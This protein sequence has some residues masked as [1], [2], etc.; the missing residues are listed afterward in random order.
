MAYLQGRNYMIPDD[1]K[2][3]AVPVLAHRLVCRGV[4]SEDHR[5]RGAQILRAILDSIAVPV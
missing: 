3:T 4:L 2:Q 5:Q 1:I